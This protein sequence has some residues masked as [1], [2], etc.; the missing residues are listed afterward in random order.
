ML[1]CKYESLSRDIAWFWIWNFFLRKDP[2][3]WPGIK[4]KFLPPFRKEHMNVESPYVLH[5]CYRRLL[6]QQTGCDNFAT[7]V[8]MLRFR[9]S[10]PF[11]TFSFYWSQYFSEDNR[12]FVLQFYVTFS[13]P[14]A[15][16]HVLILSDCVCEVYLC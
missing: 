11:K 3:C 10:V 14:R 6:S 1:S 13:F 12:Y 9:I 5:W 4:P 15:T 16:K 2:N 7:S 8:M